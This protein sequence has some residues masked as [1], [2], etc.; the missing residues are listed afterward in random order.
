MVLPRMLNMIKLFEFAQLQD[1]C[2]CARVFVSETE[3][4]GETDRE[5]KSSARSLEPCP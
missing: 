4:D 3:T 5:R 1:H 2:T